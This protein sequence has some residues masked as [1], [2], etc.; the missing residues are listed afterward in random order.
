MKAVLELRD[1]GMVREVL[2]STEWPV[3]L[4]D[5]SLVPPEGWHGG[6][7]EL[8]LE[9]NPKLLGRLS[10]RSAWASVVCRIT[11]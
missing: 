4:E 1:L 7:L 2:A 11:P 10:K 9:L 8:T 5:G 6:A 3:T